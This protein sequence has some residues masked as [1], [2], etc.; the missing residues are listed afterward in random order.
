MSAVMKREVV[1]QVTTEMERLNKSNEESA[2]KHVKEIK[3][4]PETESNNFKSGDSFPIEDDEY[5]ILPN[6]TVG[7]TLPPPKNAAET[8]NQSFS[9]KEA[10]QT[11]ILSGTSTQVT[12]QNSH[13]LRRN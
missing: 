8:A 6:Q 2:D 11:S 13:A 3:S 10:H 1:M 12:S 9:S 4:H 7:L 5:D